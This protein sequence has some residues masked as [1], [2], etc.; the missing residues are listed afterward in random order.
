M[1]PLLPT[2]Y[3]WFL[4]RTTANSNW[5]RDNWKLLVFVRH[6]PYHKIMFMFCVLTTRLISSLLLLCRRLSTIHC[7]Q[8]EYVHVFVFCLF[9]MAQQ[10]WSSTWPYCDVNVNH[11]TKRNSCKL[12][13]SILKQTVN[14]WTLEQQLYW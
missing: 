6:D 2:I 9:Y 12:L 3:N 10:R 4:H 7:Y 5:C 8:F 11:W 14:V 13:S 1:F